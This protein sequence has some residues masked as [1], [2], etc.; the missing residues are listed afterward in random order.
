MEV[1]SLKKG[2]SFFNCHKGATWAGRPVEG[3]PEPILLRVVLTSSGL[4]LI[5]RGWQL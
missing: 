4:T 1:K 5:F 3:S 2:T